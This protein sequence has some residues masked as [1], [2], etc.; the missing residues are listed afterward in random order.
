MAK[1]S[2]NT[3]VSFVDFEPLSFTIRCGICRLSY[4]VGEYYKSSH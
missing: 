4:V 1:M 2:Q 3:N